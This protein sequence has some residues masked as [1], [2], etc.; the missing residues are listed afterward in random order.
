MSRKHKFHN[1][2]AAYFVSFATVYWVD[3]FTRQ[4]CFNILEESID[5]CRREKGWRYLHRFVGTRYKRLLARLHIENTIL[6]LT[7]LMVKGLRYSHIGFR[8]YSL[9][10]IKK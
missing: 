1:P 2:T 5:Y 8:F 10:F 9:N 3:V 7:C 6:F 4:E